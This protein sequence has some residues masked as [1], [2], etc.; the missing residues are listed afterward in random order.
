MATVTKS[1]G[2]SGRDYSTISLW[3][4]D[5]DD[6]GIYSSGDDAVG[7]CY[8]DSVFDESVNINGGG[9]VGLN[10]ITLTVAEGERHDGTAGTG[11]RIDLTGSG[12]A[13]FINNGGCPVDVSI[14]WLEFTKSDGQRADSLI[15]MSTSGVGVA[16]E[17]SNI[18]AHDLGNRGPGCGHSTWSSG[19]SLVFV[20]NIFYNLVCEIFGWSSSALGWR[21]NAGSRKVHNNTVVNI[22]GD[23]PGTG[24]GIGGAYTGDEHELRN[25]ICMDCDTADFASNISDQAYN[26][27]SDSSATG[28][29]SLTGKLSSNQFVSTT[30]GSEDLHLKAGADAIDAGTD[31]GTTPSGV[32]I[33]IDGRDRD[34]EDDTWDIGAHEFAADDDESSSSSGGVYEAEG[35]YTHQK[36][37]N[38]S[39]VKQLTKPAMCSRCEIQAEGN[40]IRYRVDGGDPTSSVGHRLLS[41]GSPLALDRDIIGLARFIQEGSGA[42]LNVTYKK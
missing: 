31:L 20:N 28:T 12:A 11:A 9:T 35:N 1:I 5:L 17:V 7:E 25:N 36:I 42:E 26:L 38:L 16:R 6:G 30:G 2:T 14:H 10:S 37:V 29:G 19:S 4:A 39:V 21:Y 15:S 33:D 27:S 40:N 22:A 18:L 3:E 32:E 34:A 23:S 24:Y 41:S 13:Y 8:N